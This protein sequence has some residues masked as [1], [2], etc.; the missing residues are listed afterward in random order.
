[1]KLKNYLLING[2]VIRVG[3]DM[4][5]VFP[6]LAGKRA[7]WIEIVHQ[8]KVEKPSD[9]MRVIFTYAYYDLDGKFDMQQHQQ[10]ATQKIGEQIDPMLRGRNSKDNKVLSLPHRVKTPKLNDIEKKALQ[11]R[12]RKDLGIEININVLLGR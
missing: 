6:E 3:A 7:P 10:E 12:V 11:E 8:D 1:M 9:I 5:R 2:R 4:K